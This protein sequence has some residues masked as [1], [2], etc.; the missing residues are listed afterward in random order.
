MNN[1]FSNNKINQKIVVVGNGYRNSISD[2]LFR[3]VIEKRINNVEYLYIWDIKNP[4]TRFIQT[5]YYSRKWNLYLKFPCFK[6]LFKKYNALEKIKTMEKGTVVIINLASQYSNL[7]TIEEL[8]ELKKCGYTLVL[9]CIDSIDSPQMNNGEIVSWFSTFDLVI[10]DSPEDANKYNLFYH[11][12][13]YPWNSSEIHNQIVKN[14]IY[15]LGR[16]KN[17]TD[18]CVDIY[19]YLNK[20]NVSCDFTIVDLE[21]NLSDTDNKSNGIKIVNSKV[22]YNHILNGISQ[23]NCILELISYGNGASLRYFESIVFNKKLLTNNKDAKKLPF[24]NPK[25]MRII[26]SV[27]DID[28]EWL[29]KKEDINYNYIDEFSV[30]SFLTDV[31]NELAKKGL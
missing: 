12:D 15:F 24:F 25:F 4:I 14:D 28:I 16:G 17:R 7:T 31:R 18:L 10:S 19:N 8:S 30:I 26:D 9:F 5:R 11:M 27:E 22:P 3:D 13:P 6:K 21:K 29:K 20:K 23:S 2:N 1:N